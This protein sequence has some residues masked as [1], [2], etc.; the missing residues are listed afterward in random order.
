MAG[1][2]QQLRAAAPSEVI[3]EMACR[4]DIKCCDASQ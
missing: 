2:V 4:R 1:I 3:T